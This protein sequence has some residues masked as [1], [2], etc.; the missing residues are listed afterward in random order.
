MQKIYLAVLFCFTSFISYAQNLNLFGLSS[1]AGAY[2]VG[3]NTAQLADS[4]LKWML[5]LGTAATAMASDGTNNHFV[6]A[7]NYL[8]KTKN[9]EFRPTYT[10]ILGPSFFY[11]LNAGNAF[12]I[13]TAYR[14]AMRTDGNLVSLFNADQNIGLPTNGEIFSAGIKELIFSYAHPYTYKAHFIKAGLSLKL[15]SAF[16][17]AQ[18][19]ATAQGSTQVLNGVYTNQFNSFK[20]TDIFK[21]PTHGTG[22]DLGFVYE[23][24]PKYLEYEYQMNGKKRYAVNTDKY[25]F[26]LG[27]SIN[28]MG[29]FK[30]PVAQYYTEKATTGLNP[31]DFK[32]DFTA[33]ITQIY[34]AS[35]KQLENTFTYKLPTQTTLFAEV[36]LGKSGWNFG[37]LHK[38]KVSND[39]LPIAA[40]SILTVYPRYEKSS[41]EFALPITQLAASKQWGIGVHL[42]L[43][44]IL[45]GT[46]G[47]NTLFMKNAP[48]P[49][50]YAGFN[51]MKI[52][53]KQKDADNDA[54]SNKKDECPDT[55]GIWTFRGCPDSDGDGIK[56]RED[57]CPDH[58][59][60]LATNGCPDTDG[61]GVFD[62][63][64]S[65][66]DKPGDARYNGCPD[67]DSDGLP[68]HEDE[69]PDKAGDEE[70]GGCPDTDGDG[71]IDSEDNCPEQ[72]GSKLYRGC[73][74]T[75]NDGIVDTN[76][77]CPDLA[78][79]E[80][81]GGCPDADADGIKDSE[82]KCPNA[83]GSNT[84]NG[85]PDTDTDGLIDSEDDCPDIAGMLVLDGC[86]FST[87][88]PNSI[89]DDS[90]NVMSLNDLEAAIRLLSISNSLAEQLRGFLMNK[91]TKPSITFS[92]IKAQKL[93]DLLNER[94]VYMGFLVN[95]QATES[96][97]NRIVININN[98]E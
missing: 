71:L 54:V 97:E 55:P 56:D 44:P 47:I 45:L 25:L 43:G 29:N 84:N 76:D 81:L 22:L 31:N 64:D 48:A 73:P 15:V 17:L 30:A 49:T 82:D 2:A 13:N 50:F 98:E 11:Q 42:R 94:F 35:D 39:E 79:L 53:T 52:A 26:R 34:A 88:V 14:S 37:F 96:D 75:D 24:R 77:E 65:C 38:S 91:L 63:N 59:G 19:T 1:S 6:P 58:A 46:E 18:T 86:S 90:L 74:D 68:D 36:A 78:G 70:F 93:A 10:K 7:S 95:V 4:R 51:L 61:D 67:T 62:S 21:S 16:H 8:L 69:C 60:P 28:D 32:K 3:T 66:P 20:W 83:A 9:G 89:S 92:G 40:P 33:D 85:C 27:F 72:A 87:F 23:Y 80:N 12:A 5:N 41:L 57:K